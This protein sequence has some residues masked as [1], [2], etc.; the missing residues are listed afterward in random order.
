VKPGGIDTHREDFDEF[1]GIWKDED[2]ADFEK[3]I[4][5][6]RQI[7]AGDWE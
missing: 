5:D 4:K 2:L 6:L 3:N 7:D 1:C